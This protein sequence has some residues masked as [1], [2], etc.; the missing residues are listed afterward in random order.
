MDGLYRFVVYTY[1]GVLYDVLTA[2]DLIYSTLVPPANAL[3]VLGKQV[4]YSLFR[5]LKTCDKAVLSAAI[6]AV[7]LVPM[8]IGNI[9]QSVVQFAGDGTR[10]NSCNGH[11]TRRPPCRG[12]RDA[13]PAGGPADRFAARRGCVAGG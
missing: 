6:D 5:Q 11:C 3:S 12:R 10:T 2:A 7:G 8:F 4:S 9:G 13:L 1:N